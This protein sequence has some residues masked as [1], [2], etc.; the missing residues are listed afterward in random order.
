MRVG[1]RAGQLAQHLAGFRVGDEQIDREAGPLRQERDQLAV[2]A[3][4]RTDVEIAADAAPAL[5]DD[6]PDFRRRP[7]RVENAAVGVADRLVPLFRQGLAVDP[8]DALDRHLVIAGVAGRRQHHADD[9]VTPSSAH[10]R[11]ERLA[12]AVR[13]VL[14]IV[15]VLDLRQGFL[16]RGVAHPHRRVRVDRTDRQV[17]GHAFDEPQRETMGAGFTGR[18]VGPGGDVE[19]ERV[20]ELVADH[21]IGVGER[22]A[23]RQDDAP[24]D[25]LGDAARAFTDLARDGVGLLEVGMR[26]VEHERLASAEFVAQHLLQPRVPALGHARGDVDAFLRARIEVDVEVLGLQDL[27]VEVLVLNLVA[28]EVLRRRIRCHQAGEGCR[29]HHQPDTRNRPDVHS[30]TSCRLTGASL[31]RHPPRSTFRSHPSPRAARPF[32]RARVRRSSRHR[33]DG[34][35]DT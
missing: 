33:P 10:V 32:R 6:P 35:R 27:E 26:R 23:H 20:H 29:H 11:P 28:A 25:R 24:P 17:L 15:E 18:R 16:A 1:G 21:V 7:R 4:R 34:R 13:K 31:V 30:F 19:L 14:R 3:D 12:P 5:E 22:T 9:F 2:G 8:E